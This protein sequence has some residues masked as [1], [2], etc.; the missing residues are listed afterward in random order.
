VVVR[1]VGGRER[2]SGMELR[3]RRG[4]CPVM[5]VRGR[6]LLYLEFRI[7]IL[8]IVC[9]KRKIIGIVL[10][11]GCLFTSGYI[12]PWSSLSVHSFSLVAKVGS[13]SMTV[14]LSRTPTGT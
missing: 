3:R 7:R 11:T 9:A 13:F 4:L 14:F 5:S 8:N 6:L 12:H 10:Y 2:R 1:R